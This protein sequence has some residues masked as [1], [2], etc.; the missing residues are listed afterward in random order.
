MINCKKHEKQIEKQ[1][2]AE[3]DIL[4]GLGILLV[5]LGHTPIDGMSKVLIYSFHL[6]LFFMVSGFFYKKQSIRTYAQKL[7]K[8][9]ILPWAFFA[10]LLTL[11]SVFMGMLT[12]GISIAS[13]WRVLSSINPVNE[14]CFQLYRTI[15][16]LVCL[17]A[18]LN[19]YNILNRFVNNTWL[20]GCFAL[21]FHV[22][23][24]LL[25]IMNYNI[26]FFVDT[27]L[28]IL[29]FIFIGDITH[30]YSIHLKLQKLGLYTLVPMFMA[31]IAVVI[32]K[33][34]T[35][36]RENFFPW[37]SV[38]LSM[39]IVGGLYVLCQKISKRNS[40]VLMWCGVESLAILGFHRLI[41]EVLLMITAKMELPHWQVVIVLMVIT[42]P[43]VYALVWL[44]DR[45]C[46]QLIGHKRQKL[47]SYH[48]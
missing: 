23:G 30:R 42:L 18:S 32:F 41:F 13:V 12:N 43:V 24:Y 6:P 4:K 28:S 9:L 3:F 47:F 17:F 20:L 36:Y 40:I 10:L 35:G 19:I 8:R 33:P 37:Y 45:I 22:I 27:S 11:L 29:I 5:M 16:F 15:W 25:R 39:A 44:T 7:F 46:P 21:S 26:P 48:A 1:R 2:C 38:L 31:V 34:H 14:N